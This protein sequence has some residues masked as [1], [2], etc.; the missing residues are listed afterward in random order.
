MHP[1]YA[2]YASQIMSCAVYCN[3]PLF[4][5]VEKQ[6]EKMVEKT[7]RLAKQMY[8]H[9]VVNAGTSN[10]SLDAASGAVPPRDGE[11]RP[12]VSNGETVGSDS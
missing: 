4:C 7:G 12:L 10:R 8:S 1:L 9:L 2:S 5:S 6:V 3:V 11:D